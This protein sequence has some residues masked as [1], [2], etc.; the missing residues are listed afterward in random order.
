VSIETNQ[1][2]IGHA[3]ND[4]TRHYLH[5]QENIRLEAVERFSDAF[6]KKG[7]GVHGNILDYKKS[8]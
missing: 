7:R 8:S 1:S 3:D 6:S 2:I 5:V 4:M